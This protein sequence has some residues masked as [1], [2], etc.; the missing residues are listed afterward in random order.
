MVGRPPGGAVVEGLHQPPEVR[1]QLLGRPAAELQGTEQRDP[2]VGLEQRVAE[3]LGPGQQLLQRVGAQGGFELLELLELGADIGTGG[4][5][6]VVS[7]VSCGVVPATSPTSSSK[8]DSTRAAST[9]RS[10][11]LPAS[12]ART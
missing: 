11:R 8:A 9:G 5:G 1:Q 6:H 4:R 3:L 12:S 2:Y 10:G 7:S